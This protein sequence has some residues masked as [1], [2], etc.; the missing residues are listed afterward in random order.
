[1]TAAEISGP[2]RT[3]LDRLRCALLDPARCDRA[4]LFLLAGYAAIWTL[5]ASIV[6]SGQDLH[7]DMAELI[8]W[9]RD[10]SFGYLKHPPLA[11]WLVRS[12]FSVLPLTDWSYYL[13][14]ML[15]PTIA[16]W[17]VWRL[18]ADYLELDKRVLG[19]AL[20]TLVPFYNFH[21]LKFNANTVLLPTW[22]A[23]TFWFMRAY[24]TQSVIYS[25]LTGVGAALCLLGKYWSVF[26][27]AGLVFA[28]LIDSRR[29][30]YFRSAAPWVATITG[31]SMLAPHVVWLYQHD[32]V[33]LD[34]AFAR[35]DANSL[36]GATAHALSYLLGSFA[37]AAAPIILVL[38]TTRP[39]GATLVEM[40]WPSDRE[41]RLVAAVF[42]G[43]L[44]LPIV[45][46]LTER[47]NLTSLWS[48][49]GL[50]LLPILL[51]SAPAVKVPSIDLRRV[52]AVTFSVPLVMLI[53]APMVA[54]AIQYAGVSPNEAHARLMAAK[55]EDAW[56]QITPQP[57]RFVGCNFADQ[58]V[59]YAA[60][61]PRT[62]P[63]RAFAGNIADQVYADVYNWPRT[64][65]EPA[66][67]EA[68]LTQSGMALVCSTD[69]ASWV[70]AAAERAARDAGSRR[71]DVEITRNFLG[72]PGRPHRYVIFIIPP[73]Q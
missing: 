23:T 31:F 10:L 33:P 24:R 37:Y 9:S 8:A 70:N 48:M 69:E 63:A 22:A 30:T 40:I 62:L 20:L 29:V 43:P 68:E 3:R 57:L 46:A 5:Y 71:T 60:D 34:Y 67:T 14:A 36:V 19:V 1:M 27:I 53:V 44:L 11:A 56:H 17:I 16:L 13:L 35:H 42:W 47:I 55:T 45:G 26:L 7:P 6:R 51:L 25:A 4:V 39:S 2:I 32:F 61:R 72:I 18:S 38:A 59:A 66:S 15:M 28:A 41:R 64:P 21:A 50:T 58:V 54:V 65:G 73:Q 49:P 12:W 52:L